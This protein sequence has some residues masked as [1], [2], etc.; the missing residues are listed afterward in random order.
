MENDNNRLFCWSRSLQLKIKEYKSMGLQ[1]GDFTILD[2]YELEAGKGQFGK[3]IISLA[4]QPILDSG[5]LNQLSIKA[6]KLA[7]L[8]EMSFKYICGAV[9]FCPVESMDKHRKQFL[10]AGMCAEGWESNYKQVNQKLRTGH[11]L[12]IEIHPS[13]SYCHVELPYSPLI[14]LRVILEQYNKVKPEIRYLMWLNY[15][16]DKS[17]PMLRYMAYGKVLEI[18]N[19]KYPLRNKKY[20]DRIETYFPDMKDAFGDVTIHKL[21]DWAN[22]RADTRH[23]IKDKNTIVAHMPLTYEE[24]GIYESLIDNLAINVIR[25]EFGLEMVLL[26][27]D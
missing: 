23:Y 5:E 10:I 13:S 27:D 4:T 9:M 16:A 12:Y 22:N 25:K 7:E 26:V 18:I 19:A 11:G 2:S 20:D 21:M 1:Y 14:D 3:Y 15:E 17:T 6:Y 24:K 8:I